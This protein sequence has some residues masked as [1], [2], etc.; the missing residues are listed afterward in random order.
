MPKAAATI[1]CPD[2]P[3]P[4]AWP[5]EPTVT[6][7]EPDYFALPPLQALR[8][9]ASSRLSRYLERSP[10]RLALER[11]L[12]S[13]T[14]D[15]APVSAYELG[16]EALERAGGRGVY[17]VASG[18]VGQRT[19]HYRI[20]DAAAVRDLRRRG[21]EIGLHGHSHCPLAW[22][23]ADALRV[24]M[25]RNR[26]ELA[27]IDDEIDA[28]NFAYPFG[29]VALERKRQIAAMTDSARGIVPGINCNGFDAQHLRTYELANARLNR[30]ELFAQLERARRLRGWLIFTLHDVA[31]D[32]SPFGCSP[33]LFQAA[34]QGALARGFEIVTVAQALARSGPGIA[35]GAA[36]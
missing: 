23:D 24:E 35:S 17:F 1:A 19:K 25:E 20:V 33:D 36:A 15:D 14:F 6:Y 9:R 31:P 27:E 28:R 22:L 29:M 32:P 13:F 8:R 26:A 16:A 5:V 18:L 2:R 12:V 7:V 11:P 34:L 3:A 10:R 30:A 4:M 21:H